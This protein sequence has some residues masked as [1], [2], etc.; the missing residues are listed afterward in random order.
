MI[1]RTADLTDLERILG[2][3]GE[4]GWNPGVADAS[5]FFAAD[6]GGFFVAEVD[7]EPVASISVV[8][9]TDDFAFLGLYICRPGYRGRGIG[10]GLWRHAIA[11]AGERTIGLDGVPDQQSNYAASGF[12]WAGETRRFEGELSGLDSEQVRVAGT[13]DVSEL[14]AKEARVT[15]VVKSALNAEWFLD[16]GA[17]S[18]FILGEVAA[19]GTAR[20]CQNGTKIGP[21]VAKTLEDAEVLVRHI[22][23]R[24]PGPMILDVP[25]GS[26]ALA[27]WCAGQGMVVSFGTARM[28]RGTPPTAQAAVTSVST[29]EL[30]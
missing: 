25:S 18:T 17:R 5:A 1:F 28:Y 29:L 6:P 23:A 13:S 21:L 30:G 22:S 14:T 7:G 26:E 24:F 20:R 12:V 8:N 27:D 9:H 2:W 15:G 3:A 10:Y 19:F 4:E 11:H 16:V